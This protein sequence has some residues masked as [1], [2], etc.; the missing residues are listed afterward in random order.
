MVDTTATLSGKPSDVGM[1][2]TLKGCG[3]DNGEGSADRLSSFSQKYEDMLNFVSI[4]QSIQS[5]KGS[6]LE[7]TAGGATRAGARYPV[8]RQ[9]ETA[10][11]LDE[12]FM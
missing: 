9:T 11:L 8:V 1:N 3:G 12:L 4:S 2:I 7:D 5:R 10:S 6:Q